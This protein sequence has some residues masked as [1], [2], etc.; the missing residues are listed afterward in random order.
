MLIPLFLKFQR[1][2]VI[3]IIS[4]A[5]EKMKSF[6]KKSIRILKKKV[7]SIYSANSLFQHQ[8]QIIK[9]IKVVAMNRNYG[10]SASLLINRDN[11]GQTEFISDRPTTL[12]FDLNYNARIGLDIDSLK[13]QFNNGVYVLNISVE[14]ENTERDPRYEDIH[15]GPIGPRVE[16]NSNGDYHSQNGHG[17]DVIM[18]LPSLGGGGKDIIRPLDPP[19]RKR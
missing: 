5:L 17:Q 3:L 12:T 18:P 9:R 1:I 15:S 14:L 2:I 13:L 11:Y 4:L 19:R 6:D 16:G 7:E 10:A 8:G